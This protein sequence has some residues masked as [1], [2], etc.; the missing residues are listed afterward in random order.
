MIGAASVEPCKDKTQNILV[1]EGKDDCHSIYQIA[2]RSG[3]AP[4]GI[5]EGES[6]TGALQ[7][8]GGLLV[9]SNAG[10]KILGIVLDCDAGVSPRWNQVRERLRAVSYDIPSAPSPSGTI[11]EGPPGYPRI[12]IWLMPDNQNEGMFEDFLLTLVPAPA[13]AFAQQTTR[14]ARVHGHATYK[15][16]HESKAVAHTYL[17]WQDEPGKPFGIGI[18]AGMF[19]LE[20]PM[21]GSFVGWLRDLFQPATSN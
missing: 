12:G 5:W 14:T 17:A 11:I 21:A 9:S 20:N 3:L 19:D 7:R 6:D 13:L 1:V 10:P 4:F 16:I 2:A 15:Q 8:F 18:K